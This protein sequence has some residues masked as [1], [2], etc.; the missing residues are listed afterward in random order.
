MELLLS[1][2][3]TQKGVIDAESN[4][5]W[6]CYS[7]ALCSFQTSLY[8]MISGEDYKD[9]VEWTSLGKTATA[10]CAMTVHKISGHVNSHEQVIKSGKDV[11]QSTRASLQ[12]NT[13][14]EVSTASMSHTENDSGNSTPTNGVQNKLTWKHHQWSTVNEYWQRIYCHDENDEV[15]KWDEWSWWNDIDE[16]KD[17]DEQRVHEEFINGYEWKNCHDVFHVK[18]EKKTCFKR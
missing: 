5:R 14:E 10:T 7:R 12:P 13:Y 15:D 2:R 1:W 8:F 17:V 6:S 3:N 9:N 4:S 18:G 16:N 11:D